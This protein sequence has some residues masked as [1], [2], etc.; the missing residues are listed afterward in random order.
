MD[1]KQND[2]VYYVLYGNVMESLRNCL[3]F[4]TEI[5]AAYLVGDFAVRTAPEA[6]S[7]KDNFA[8]RYK[9]GA[10]MTLCQQ[11]DSV[12]RTSIASDGYPF[13]TGKIEIKTDLDFKCGDP[14][15][16]KIEGRYAT[17]DVYVNGSFAHTMTFSNYLDIAEYLKEGKNTVK[18]VLSTNNRNLLGPHHLRDAEPLSVGPKSFSLEGMWDGEKCASYVSDYAFVRFGFYD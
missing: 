16:L 12:N 10:P 2:Y 5:E 7:N 17:C 4:D 3:N 15:V 13:F 9:F 1:Y 14:T 8:L 18:L 6:F 11:K